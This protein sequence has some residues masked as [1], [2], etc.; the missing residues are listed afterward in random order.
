[1]ETNMEIKN[2]KKTSSQRMRLRTT[3]T[4]MLCSGMQDN[5]E[6][7][8]NHIE[9]GKLFK[10]KNSQT[11]KNSMTK[12]LNIKSDIISLTHLS[13]FVHFLRKLSTVSYLS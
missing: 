3:G 2:E 13:A 6:R 1:M 12:M 4:S 9:R 8:Q 11:R 7:T 10:R 5:A